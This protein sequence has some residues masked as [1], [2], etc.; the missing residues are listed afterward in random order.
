L[1]IGLLNIR[2]A[3]AV[4]A[5][6]TAPARSVNRNPLGQ[7]ASQCLGT[8]GHFAAAHRLQHRCCSRQSKCSGR[9][10]GAPGYFALGFAEDD[11]L[12]AFVD[13][14]L[15]QWNNDA[16][17]ALVMQRLNE[18]WDAALRTVRSHKL[19]DAGPPNHTLPQ[20]NRPRRKMQVVAP[21][22]PVETAYILGMR[23]A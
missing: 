3:V 20:R 6:L 14:S 19:Q 16:P 23:Q 15:H 22:P 11:H 1:L 8:G 17:A 10:H 13:E 18:G 4:L 7:R 9:V 5:G 21:N 12:L 2:V